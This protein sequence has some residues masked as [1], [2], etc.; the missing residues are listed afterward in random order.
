[1][2]STVRRRPLPALIALIA[3][4]VLTGLVWWRVLNRSGASEHTAVKPCPTITPAVRLPAQS[5]VTIA[6]FN[7]TTKRGI[8]GAARQTLINDG[9]DVPGPAANAPVKRINKIPAAAEISFGPAAR[10]GALL[11]RYYF[12][13]ATMVATKSKSK[14]VSVSLGKRY[15]AVAPV[16]SVT[17]ALR[18]DH[19]VAGTPTT[20]ATPSSGATCPS[21]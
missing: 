12:P 19:T 10:Q 14:I 6:V 9:F 18:R 16:K 1:M 3:L 11:V 21:V 4:L 8:A 13:G 2:A 5:A 20:A 15:S 17:A 7:A